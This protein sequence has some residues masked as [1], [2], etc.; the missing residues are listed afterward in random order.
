MMTINFDRVLLT[1]V[2]VLTESISQ[3]IISKLSFTTLNMIQNL[4]DLRLDM[5]LLLYFCKLDSLAY[6]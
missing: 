2:S 3:D 1:R 4:S 6:F 5:Y